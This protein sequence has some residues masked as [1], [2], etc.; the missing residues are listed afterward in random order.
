M[1]RLFDP[2]PR[3]PRPRLDNFFSQAQWHSTEVENWGDEIKKERVPV[4]SGT[5]ASA[6]ERADSQSGDSFYPLVPHEIGTRTSDPEA[7]LAHMQYERRHGLP[8]SESA[9]ETVEN[10]EFLSLAIADMN[11]YDED[12]DEYYEWNE[13]IDPMDI[14]NPATDE[15]EAGLS[16]PYQNVAED[17][18]SLSYLSP[19]G[20][21]STA[22]DVVK[23][24]EPGYS[25][26]EHFTRAELYAQGFGETNSERQF[27]ISSDLRLIEEDTKGN[28]YMGEDHPLV[29]H[30]RK[31]QAGEPAR[32]PYEHRRQRNYRT[33]NRDQNF[34][35][36]HPN[37]RPEMRSL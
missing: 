27:R 14:P 35:E 28:F 12:D 34:V 7:N 17:D 10:G 36:H 1:D 16:I 33:Q 8:L 26:R 19:P 9:A 15:L 31:K 23:Q 3:S 32:F 11:P 24:I 20:G 25:P 37:S 2:G 18:G 6:V 29:E 4:H 13:M 21:F 30:E 5:L 22:R